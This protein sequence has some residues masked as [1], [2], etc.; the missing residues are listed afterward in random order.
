MKQ[1]WVFSITNKDPDYKRY[2]DL[3]MMIIGL[4]N[5]QM[6]F[7]VAK[8]K[9]EEAKRLAGIKWAMDEQQKIINERNPF[10]KELDELL[11]D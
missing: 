6:F 2:K 7:N 1:E 10:N 3:Q 11:A 5:P 8:A 4:M 9:I